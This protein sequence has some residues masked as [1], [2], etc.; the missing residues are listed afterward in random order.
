MGGANYH[1]LIYRGSMSYFMALNHPIGER[2]SVNDLIEMLINQFLL[3]F[4]CF[5]PPPF[6]SQLV[7]LS[8]YATI[9]PEAA[10]K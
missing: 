9:Q 8:F 10:T 5:K 6:P 1:A 2:R 3:T 7:S 4:M